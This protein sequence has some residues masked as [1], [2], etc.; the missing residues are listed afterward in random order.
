MDPH[1]GTLQRNHAAVQWL[2]ASFRCPLPFPRERS[3]QSA[4]T[5]A[6]LQ[7]RQ[8]RNTVRLR[9]EALSATWSRPNL[10]GEYD[11]SDEKLQDT[12]G[13]KPPKLT[14]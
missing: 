9:E 5:L 8:K 7:K 12:V 6:P 11:F 1:P 10:L 13:I 3:R 2:L 4:R 14:D